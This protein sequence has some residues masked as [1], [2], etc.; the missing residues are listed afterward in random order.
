MNTKVD[1]KKI[2]QESAV[3][4]KGKNGVL[5]FLSL[6][7]IAVS[8]V[9]NLYYA[10]KYP[11]AIRVVAVVILL[12][13]ALLAAAFTSQGKKAREFLKQSRSELNKIVWPARSETT[14][15]TLIVMVVTVVTSLILWG[16]DTVIVSLINFITSLRF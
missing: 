14:Q 16:F 1:K 6:V 8:A 13:L 3:E 15:T 2:S 4:S 5:W 11:T 12:V 9:G 7:L 10:D